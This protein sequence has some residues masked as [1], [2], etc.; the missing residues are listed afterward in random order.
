MGH[1]S[2]APLST[3]TLH[4]SRPHCRSS[5][6]SV[7]TLVKGFLQGSSTERGASWRSLTIDSA[8]QDEAISSAAARHV[9]IWLRAGSE[10]PAGAPA[11]ET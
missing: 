7:D 5:V 8:M 2:G 11:V 9:Y 1:P 6:A 4:R 10:D 3:D